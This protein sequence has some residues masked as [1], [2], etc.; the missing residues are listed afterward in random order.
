MS[1]R[2]QARVVV[3][4]WV[5]VVVCRGGTLPMYTLPILACIL[6]KLLVPQSCYV[7][8]NILGNIEA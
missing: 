4:D 8:Q 7:M 5:G 2:G 3:I 1:I 6:A